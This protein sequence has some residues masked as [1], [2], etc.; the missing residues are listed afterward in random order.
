[1]DALSA[2]KLLATLVAALLVFGGGA[3]LGYQYCDGQVAKEYADAKDAAIKRVRE[4]A[5][6]DKQAAVERAQREAVATERARSAR[7]KGVSDASLK[8]KSGCDRDAES[9]SLLLDAINAANGTKEPTGSVPER[10]PDRPSTKKWLR[11]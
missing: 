8:A 2:E 10:V 7:S 5:E 4:D 9:S 3:Y 1:M 6:A 11:P